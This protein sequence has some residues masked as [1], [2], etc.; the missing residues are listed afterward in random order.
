MDGVWRAT[1]HTSQAHPNGVR[2]R[3]ND[4][5]IVGQPVGLRPTPANKSPP[6]M[7]DTENRRMSPVAQAPFERRRTKWD[8]AFGLLSVVAGGVMLGHV[9]LAS[10]VS[11]LFLGWTLIIGGI[12]VFVSAITTWGEPGHW[13]GV[14]AGGLLTVLGVG[15]VR[16]PGASLLVLTLLAGSLLIVGGIVRLVAA[17]QPGAPKGILIVNGAATLLLGLLVFFQWPVSALW[18][19][20][21]VLGVQLILDGLTTA[22]SGRVR[23]VETTRADAPAT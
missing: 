12:V 8:V 23:V 15:F 11:V 10:L 5:H 1:W 20:G 7:N 16:N 9:A 4:P 13:W 14:I 19:L 6:A 18:Y 21:M 3:D 2:I 17:F 22:I